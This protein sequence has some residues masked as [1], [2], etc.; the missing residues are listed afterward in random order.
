MGDSL[1]CKV[2]WPWPRL[3]AEIESRCG[4]TLRL[5]SLEQ[6][7]EPIEECRQ[8]ML[9]IWEECTDGVDQTK[10]Y[11][12][13]LSQLP[14][15]SAQ[16]PERVRQGACTLEDLMA[17]A[18]QAQVQ[19]KAL[20]APGNNA[21]SHMACSAMQPGDRMNPERCWRSPLDHNIL[22]DGNHYDPGLKTEA[23]VLKKAAAIRRHEDAMAFRDVVDV[24][25]I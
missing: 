10:E 8:A 23:Q 21:W 1:V 24:S 4:L 20:L 12:E 19:L 15:D 17:D 9:A 16:Y 2:S 5:S 13:L 11:D 6:L 25:R 14:L 22:A 7:A 3:Q 18:A